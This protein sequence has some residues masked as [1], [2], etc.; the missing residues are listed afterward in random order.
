MTA[1]AEQ[2]QNLNDRLTAVE[3]MAQTE[4]PN[5]RGEVDRA[6]NDLTKLETTSLQQM[7]ALVN[8]LRVGFE[9]QEAR[10][11]EL[12]KADKPKPDNRH[13]RELLESHAIQSMEKLY[14]NKNYRQWLERFKNALEQARPGGSRVLTFLCQHKDKDVSDMQTSL[15]QQGKQGVFAEFA[16]RTMLHHQQ[17]DV[18]AC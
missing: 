17:A 16:I 5:W 4:L 18:A 9:S 12:E 11:L 10:I 7:C 14:D 8:T 1:T 3:T 6:F 13:R 2:I 15:I